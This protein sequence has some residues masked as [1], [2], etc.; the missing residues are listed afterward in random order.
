MKSS[1]V[2]LFDRFE[3]EPVA[4]G[5]SRIDQLKESIAEYLIMKMSDEKRISFFKEHNKVLNP[6][7]VEVASLEASLDESFS[8]L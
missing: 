7:F 6:M 4:Q 5:I 8:S 2:A 3:H 1:L